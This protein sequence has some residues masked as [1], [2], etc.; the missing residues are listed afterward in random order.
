MTDKLVNGQLV[1]MSQ[2][3]VDAL[4]AS[5]VPSQEKLHAY[6]AQKRWEVETG[7]IVFSSMPVPTDDRAKALITGA[8]GSSKPD[9]DV[10]KFKV[11]TSWV[12]L[13]LAQI[14]AIQDA[15]TNHVQAAFDTEAN[16]SADITAGNITTFA[17]IDGAAWPSNT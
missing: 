6:A 16:V 12:D 7:G 11:G 4:E 8:A 17:E 1:T 13:T 5:R 2:A 10:V 9:T 14:R 15:I 3:E